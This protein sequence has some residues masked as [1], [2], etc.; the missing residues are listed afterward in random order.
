MFPAAAST[1]APQVDALYVYLVLLS[2]VMTTLIFIAIGFFAYKYRRR[3][4]DDPMPRAIHGSIPIELTWSVIPF[5]FMLV[6]FAWGT[7]L[8]FENYTPPR[9]TLDIY[10][11]GK[12]WMWK[13][14]YP[15]GQREINE[16]HVPTGR[17]VKLTLASEDVI[18]SFYIPAFRLKH[19]VVPGSYQTYWFQATEP[20]RYHLFCAEYCGTNH[21]RMI[22]WVDVM[23]PVSYQ[24]WL[25][26]GATGA[27][28]SQLG[29]KLFEKYGCVT[30]HVTNHNG[31][32]LN[33]VFG[34]P[35]Q[36]ADGRTVLADE[37][38]LRE[39][40]LNPNAKVVKGYKPNVMPVYQGQIDEEGLLQLIVYIKSLSQTNP[41]AIP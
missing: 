38:F 2:V 30:C 19:D 7:K 1:A 20:G 39:S 12:Q 15:D 5:L 34:H 3:S 32:P 22:G 31:P 29:E 9:N 13:V 26:G 24:N 36:L 35:V 21:S 37:P 10:V 33:N 17:P 4:P 11:V 18:H 40:I 6:M 16:L 14:Q 25:A 23:D 41:Q 28:M 27:T 8:Y